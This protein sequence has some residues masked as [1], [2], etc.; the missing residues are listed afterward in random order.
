MLA[1]NMKHQF[2]SG[3][4]RGMNDRPMSHRISIVETLKGEMESGPV[5]ENKDLS[6]IHI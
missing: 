1:L 4:T 2:G 3:K 6:L 5:G